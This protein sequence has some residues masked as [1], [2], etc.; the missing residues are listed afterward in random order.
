M[1]VCRYWFD[2]TKAVFPGGNPSQAQ[3]AEYEEHYVCPASA[4]A[5]NPA[6]SAA[7]ALEIGRIRVLHGNCKVY[8]P[9]TT[10]LN[11]DTAAWVAKFNY[12]QTNKRWLAEEAANK[13]D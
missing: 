7:N 2:V 8:R 4:P 11:G 13:F 1:Q 6:P 5:P 12:W 10:E 3:W 9:G